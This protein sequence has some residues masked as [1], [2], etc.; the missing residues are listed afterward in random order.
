[1][2]DD[3]GI[4]QE[5]VEEAESQ[6]EATTVPLQALEDERQK[7]QNAEKQ[8]AELRGKVE[9]LSQQ[10]Q[11]NETAAKEWTTAEIK[12][13]VNTGQISE[14]EAERIRQAQWKREVKQ[15]VTQEISQTLNQQSVNQRVDS[16]IQRYVK[17]IPEL[18][19]QSSDTFGKVKKEFDYLTTMLGRDA[20]DIGTQLQ[21]VRTVFG[22]IEALEKVNGKPAIMPHQEVGGQGQ[23]DRTDK[24]SDGSPN[25]LPREVRQFYEKQFEMGM[26]SGWQDNRVKAEIEKYGKRWRS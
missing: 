20:N 8:V 25:W 22:D 21:A 1:M 19:N 15:E 11:G 2:T 13:A 10:P 23:T 26:Y 5:N 18:S 4:S 3:T 14:D 24:K 16:E 9:I 17:I 12:E 6:Q 7:R